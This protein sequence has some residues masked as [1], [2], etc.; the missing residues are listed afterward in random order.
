MAADH[1]ASGFNHLRETSG[2]NSVENFQIRLFRKTHQSQ[3][4]E[5][6]SSHRVN[7]AQRIGRGD[8]A[9]DIRIV[10]HRREKIYRLHQ[11]LVGRDLIHSGVV[12]V[13]KAD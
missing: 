13:V 9:E 10:N 5:R 4:G 3:R 11:R 8:L 6:L 7:I 1:G 2:Q 12:G